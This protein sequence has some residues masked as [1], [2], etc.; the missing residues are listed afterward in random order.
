MSLETKLSEIHETF[1]DNETMCK[2]GQSNRRATLE[3][4]ENWPENVVKQ[5]VR[6]RGRELVDA[7]QEVALMCT[8]QDLEI[9][10]VGL[11]QEKVVDIR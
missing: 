6:L 1:E 7:V 9:E 4:Q 11:Q 5:K 3:D 8:K 10:R 2:A